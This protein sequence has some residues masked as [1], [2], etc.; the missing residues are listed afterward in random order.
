MSPN[1]DKDLMLVRNKSNKIDMEMEGEVQDGHIISLRQWSVSVMSGCP[2]PQTTEE[3]EDYFFE[4][5]LNVFVVRDGEAY[6]L[7]G[8]CDTK[9]ARN[10]TIDEF[11]R[12]YVMAY[13]D[14]DTGFY[15]I[16]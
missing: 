15:W 5:C 8:D 16:A 4:K 10:W 13:I 6:P 9:C 1:N 12:T 7:N 11:D 3:W 2:V 14:E